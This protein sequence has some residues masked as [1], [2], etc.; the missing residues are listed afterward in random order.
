MFFILCSERCDL[1]RGF[2]KHCN[3][4]SLRIKTPSHPNSGKK[5][6]PRTREPKPFCLSNTVPSLAVIF[7]FHTSPPQSHAL[8][9][10]IYCCVNTQT[11]KWDSQACQI[12]N[13][14]IAFMKH[15]ITRYMA[16]SILVRDCA[17]LTIISLRYFNWLQADRSCSLNKSQLKMKYW[18]DSGFVEIAGPSFRNNRLSIGE[19]K[20]L[21]VVCHV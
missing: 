10:N 11:D 19:E 18:L 15:Q 3:P 16:V 1:L 5:K 2:W 21:P 12:L 6:R 14:K 8:A 9:Y 7:I 13:K 20:I 4:S 17:L